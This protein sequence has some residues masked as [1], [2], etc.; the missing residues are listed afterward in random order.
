[1]AK[2]SEQLGGYFQ[3]KAANLEEIADHHASIGES[4][5]AKELYKQAR[6]MYAKIGATDAITRLDGKMK[7]LK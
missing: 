1:M 4:S 7:K 6:E 3:R 5:K 2:P